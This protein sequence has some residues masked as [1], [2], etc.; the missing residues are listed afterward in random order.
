MNIKGTSRFH[1]IQEVEQTRKNMPPSIDELGRPAY[2]KQLRID[3][4]SYCNAKCTICPYDSLK[5][6]I[7]MGV[8]EENLF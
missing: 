2:P 6:K 8:M 3:I 1:S 4:H 5:S 7:P